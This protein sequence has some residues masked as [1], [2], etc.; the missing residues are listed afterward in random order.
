VL[1]QG[2]FRIYL[3]CKRLNIKG[4]REL[5][6]ERTLLY[7]LLP[8]INTS[9]KEQDGLNFADTSSNQCVD[10]AMDKSGTVCE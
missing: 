7:Q 3:C 10:K 6:T 4:K 8:N 5:S 9:F 2:L 1:A